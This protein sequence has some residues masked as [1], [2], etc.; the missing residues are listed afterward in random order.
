MMPKHESHLSSLNSER[1]VHLQLD[2][3][4][5]DIVRQT[6]LLS[7]WRYLSARDNRENLGGPVYF[8]DNSG[9]V[10]SMLGG[11]LLPF[12]E[13]PQLNMHRYAVCIHG[14]DIWV[15]RPRRSWNSGT[16]ISWHFPF[17]FFWSFGSS[18]DWSQC[19]TDIDWTTELFWEKSA[20]QLVLHEWNHQ[21]RNLVQS[22]NYKLFKWQTTRQKLIM[23][24]VR[25]LTSYQHSP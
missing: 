17:S 1:Q 20:D 18:R 23:S 6:R 8:L 21:K 22:S 15:V 24:F 14:V 19:T 2:S 25:Q 3:S 10:W 7:F 16:T 9:C 12:S 13:G 5:P 11:F 4:C